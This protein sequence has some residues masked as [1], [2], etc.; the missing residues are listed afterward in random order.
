MTHAALRS[1]LSTPQS[2]HHKLKG[3]GYITDSKINYEIIGRFAGISGASSSIETLQVELPTKTQLLR[4]QL[5]LIL[6][7]EPGSF[8]ST[9]LREV[10]KIWGVTP[11]SNV[12]APAMIGTIDQSNGRLVPGLVWQ[13]RN[14]PL[15]LDEF[16]TNERG[17]SG[18]VDV[19]LGTME[20][21]HYKRKLGLPSVYFY[22]NEGPLFYRAE[23]G[24]IEVQTR[25]ST[26]IATMR[27][28][29]MTRSGKY[30]ALTQ[31]CIPI[32][33]S[34]DLQ[35]FDAVLDGKPVYRHY[36]YK[37]KKAVSI[38]RKDFADI[39]AI[40][41][42][43]ASTGKLDD[44]KRVYIR[45]IDD[46]SRI[47]AV[48]GDFDAKQFRLVCYLKAGLHLEEALKKLEKD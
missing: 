47:L 32:R 3:R 38:S 12:T 18:A 2:V 46:L 1:T 35:A 45:S 30:E 39:R 41:A 40:A 6:R 17:D 9:L 10:G 5:H 25:F 8:K 43:V 16:K 33:Y 29:D 27:N 48:T 11:Y 23:N 20:D 21:G 31:R 7:S 26:I 42:D 19:L 15:L 4:P 44:F 34:M 22:E 24:E 37:P 14:K 36:D 28:W 13:T